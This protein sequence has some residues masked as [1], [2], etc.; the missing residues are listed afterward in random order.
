MV[1]ILLIQTVLAN[2]IRNQSGLF[3]GENLKYTTTG[4]L[5]LF[6]KPLKGSVP[7]TRAG[8]KEVPGVLVTHDLRVIEVA[9]DGKLALAKLKLSDSLSGTKGVSGITA[10]K[11][12]EISIEQSQQRS[13]KFHKQAIPGTDFAKF[14]HEGKCIVWGHDRLKLGSCD[15]QASFLKFPQE[16]GFTPSDL[17]SF[18]NSVAASFF[19]ALA[20]SSYKSMLGG[21]NAGNA[22]SDDDSYGSKVARLV[23]SPDNA[24]KK[25]EQPEKDRIVRNREASDPRES[26]SEE[27]SKLEE[28]DLIEDLI[29]E[30]LVSKY[31]SRQ[32][33]SPRENTMR[34][35]QM[36]PANALSGAPKTPSNAYY[37]NQPYSFV[38][39]N[40]QPHI[41]VRSPQGDMIVPYSPSPTHQEG[42]HFHG[43]GMLY[44]ETP[45]PNSEVSSILK[46]LLLTKVMDGKRL[47]TSQEKTLAKMLMMMLLNEEAG[48]NPSYEHGGRSVMTPL[49]MSLLMS[50]DY[51]GSM[52]RNAEE[53][54]SIARREAKFVALENDV[55]R[56][57]EHHEIG[58]EADKKDK[59]VKEELRKEI[60][61]QKSGGGLGGLFGGLAK[62]TPQGQALSAITEGQ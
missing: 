58:K 51:D 62:M 13:V 61:K 34:N 45:N 49:I 47:E 44:H 38:A 15:S 57:K 32:A 1:R 41:V 54:R 19:N 46:I 4:P 42:M 37:P 29:A 50:K 36:R 16:Y 23:R 48:V 2:H 35:N 26:G 43:D 60:K 28:G 3:V 52:A 21:R 27:E 53:I 17:E 10:D 11:L 14:F 18:K 6:F 12:N 20:P 59:T 31:S 5:S 25:I 9:K 8:Q 7:L 55:E 56:L 40:G 30:L 24:E 39:I 22:N 33:A